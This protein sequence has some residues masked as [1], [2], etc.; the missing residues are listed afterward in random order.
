MDIHVY[1]RSHHYMRMNLLEVIT[2]QYLALFASNY[3]IIS[4]TNV[5]VRNSIYF[6]D[7]NLLMF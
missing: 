3:D 6:I 5:C 2:R 4:R 1:E 7:A